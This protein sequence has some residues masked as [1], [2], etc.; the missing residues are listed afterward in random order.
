MFSRRHIVQDR[1]SHLFLGFEDGDIAPVP[2]I[3]HAV[4]FETEESAVLTALGWCDSGYVL[5][6]FYLDIGDE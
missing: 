4:K 6:S 1:E 5:F 3:K 2:L